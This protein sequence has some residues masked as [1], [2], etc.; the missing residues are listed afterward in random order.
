MECTFTV[1]IHHQKKRYATTTTFC[2]SLFMM[3][4]VGRKSATASSKH[5]GLIVALMLNLGRSAPLLAI[6]C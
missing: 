5:K 6:H 2:I 1:L 3:Q 4:K